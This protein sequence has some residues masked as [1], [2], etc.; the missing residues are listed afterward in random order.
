MTNE[1]G[2]VIPVSVPVKIE[3]GDSL[4]TL[5]KVRDGVDGLRTA[6][7]VLKNSNQDS[8][9]PG[10]VKGMDEQ[11]SITEDN[12][13]N[14]LYSRKQIESAQSPHEKDVL[15]KN[16]IQSYNRAIQSVQNL[17]RGVQASNDLG[18]MLTSE[19][20]DV[21]SEALRPAATDLRRTLTATAKTL[22]AKSGNQAIGTIIEHALHS[23]AL[24]GD[25][26]RSRCD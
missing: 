19:V 21:F 3:T 8:V 26:Q 11:I 6:I 17:F 13:N 14:L 20:H 9:I 12:I 22:S 7:D 10:F 25:R 24:M 2:I 23:D 16:F 15:Q 4:P 5:D 1:S 18:E